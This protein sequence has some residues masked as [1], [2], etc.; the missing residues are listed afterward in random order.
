MTSSLS[1]V[2]GIESRVRDAIAE[3]VKA[4]LDDVASGGLA[5]LA[6]LRAHPNT[7]RSDIVAKL[8]EYHS[9]TLAALIEAMR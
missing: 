9:R 2:A 3:A 6:E 1:G 8:M 4:G 7:D 5:L